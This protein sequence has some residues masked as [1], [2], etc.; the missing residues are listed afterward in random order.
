MGHVI[1]GSSTPHLTPNT[2]NA[3]LRGTFLVFSVSLTS[4]KNHIPHGCGF[5]V[6]AP[7]PTL[8]TQKAHPHRHTFHFHTSLTPPSLQHEHH[9]YGTW[10]SWSLPPPLPPT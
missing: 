2:R 9:I 4:H 7:F 10:C 1:C 8:P 3:S 6:R 5:H